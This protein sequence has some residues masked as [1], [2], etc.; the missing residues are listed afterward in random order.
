MTTE[1]ELPNPKIVVYE[2]RDASNK[3]T[4]EYGWRLRADNGNIIA[5]DGGQGYKDREFTARMAERIIKDGEFSDAPIHH[6]Y[7]KK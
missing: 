5:T 7:P 3:P 6:M 4:G 1:A 2:R